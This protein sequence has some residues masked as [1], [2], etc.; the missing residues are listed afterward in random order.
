M[1]GGLGSFLGDVLLLLVLP[2]VVVDALVAVPRAK[3]LDRDEAAVE[4]VELDRSAEFEALV[5]EAE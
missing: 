5:L 4:D 1:E 2:L 3:E